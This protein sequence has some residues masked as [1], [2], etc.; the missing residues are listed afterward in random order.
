MPKTAFGRA[1]LA[2]RVDFV[3]C[4][5]DFEYYPGVFKFWL[6]CCLAVYDDAAGLLQVCAARSTT[7][8]L[9]SLEVIGAGS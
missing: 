2:P 1:R 8:G 9:L 6:D 5:L 3:S 7:V 4:P